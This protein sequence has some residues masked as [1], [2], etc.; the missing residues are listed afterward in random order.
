M[1]NEGLRERALDLASHTVVHTTSPTQASS[2][3]LASALPL[4]LLLVGLG[5]TLGCFISKWF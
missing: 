4:S 3:S 5:S 2:G 1:P